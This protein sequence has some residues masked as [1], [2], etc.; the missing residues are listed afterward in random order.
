MDEQWIE[1]SVR[2]NDGCYPNSKLFF[3]SQAVCSRVCSTKKGRNFSQ[4]ET[5]A[6]GVPVL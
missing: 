2:L 1:D 6:P 3:A 5:S 4:K